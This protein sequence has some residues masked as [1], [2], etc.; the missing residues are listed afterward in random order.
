LNS[1]L[2]AL[3]VFLQTPPGIALW[4]AGNLV[5][6]TCIIAESIMKYSVQGT[7]PRY[8]AAT[9]FH[10]LLIPSIFCVSV[11]TLIDA[12]AKEWVGVALGVAFIVALII[13]WHRC[14]DEDSWWKGKG[15]KLKKLTSTL[16]SR[17]PMAVGGSA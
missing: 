11:S 1:G 9:V 2:E 17:S 16:S 8:L 5:V 10:T 3:T 6:L 15:T 14:K 4:L 13:A 7:R 12:A